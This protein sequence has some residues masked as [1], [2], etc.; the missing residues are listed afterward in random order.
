MDNIIDN[1]YEATCV[2]SQQQLKE[3]KA[4]VHRYCQGKNM[5]A[6]PQPGKLTWKINEN[7]KDSEH[8][9]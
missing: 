6:P 1:R 4:F 9:T 5:A 2:R 3:I 7:K 8:L